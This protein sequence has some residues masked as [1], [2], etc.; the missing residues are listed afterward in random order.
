[1]AVDLLHPGKSLGEEAPPII[2]LSVIQG[3]LAKVLD[4][5]NR[6]SMAS[7]SGLTHGP[8]AALHT[9]LHSE[10]PEQYQTDTEKIT[11]MLMMASPEEYRKLPGWRRQANEIATQIVTDPLTILG[12]AG[13]ARK[14]VDKAAVRML[15]AVMGTASFLILRMRLRTNTA[16]R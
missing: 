15:P 14:G 1:M 2:P 7:T 11:Q 10:S 3:A 4:V 6:T 13:I 16:G 5:L 12:G 8:G 9:L